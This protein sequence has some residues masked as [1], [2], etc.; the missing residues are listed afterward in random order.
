M[1]LSLEQWKERGSNQYGNITNAA[2]GESIFSSKSWSAHGDLLSLLN[3]RGAHTLAL[4]PAS[5]GWRNQQ[6]FLL[7]CQNLASFAF[8]WNLMKSYRLEFDPGKFEN[9]KE[10]KVVRYAASLLPNFIEC[11]SHA[12]SH[13]DPVQRI[14]LQYC[15]AFGIDKNVAA[16]ESSNFIF[17]LRLIR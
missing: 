7:Q 4:R 17:P 3:S 10:E 1:I 15:N 5:A 11:R 6:T 8:W 12:E 2:C 13:C 16:S 14:C 9:Q